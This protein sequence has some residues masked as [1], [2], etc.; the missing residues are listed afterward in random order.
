L[1][2]YIFTLKHNAML[3]YNRLSRRFVY[4]IRNT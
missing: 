1:I 3:Y 2:L 4:M